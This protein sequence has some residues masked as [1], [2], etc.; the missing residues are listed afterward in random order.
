MPAAL[1]VA[2]LEVEAQHA[3]GGRRAR[4]RQARGDHPPDRAR[5]AARASGRA[6]CRPRARRGGRAGARRP[7]RRSAAAASRAARRCTRRPGRRSRVGSRPASRRIRQPDSTARRVSSAS[8]RANSASGAC[9]ARERRGRRPS[10]APVAACRAGRAGRSRRPWRGARRA[11]PRGPRRGPAAGAG[12]A[13]GRR[14]GSRARCRGRSSQSR[15]SATFSNVAGS[16]SWI[17]TAISSRSVLT[18]PPARRLAGVSSAAV[19]PWSSASAGRCCG[20]DL[21]QRAARRGRTTTPATRAH[22]SVPAPGARCRSRRSGSTP[23][24]STG[25]AP[26]AEVV[27]HVEEDDV[28]RARRSDLDRV[29][30]GDVR[31]DVQVPEVEQHPGRG[32]G[33]PPHEVAHRERVVAHPPRP[34]ED[35]REVLDRD[36]DAKRVRLLEVLRQ[37]AFLEQSALPDG[38]GVRPVIVREVQSVVGDELRAGLGGVLEQPGERAVGARR[39]RRSGRRARGARGAAPSGRAAR[40]A[41]GRARAARPA[42][43]ARPRGGAWNCTQRNPAPD[44]LGEDPARRP[45]LTRDVQPEPQRQVVRFGTVHACKLRHRAV[46]RC[47]SAVTPR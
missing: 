2:R 4:P 12:R 21:E 16:T 28:A 40:A 36:G 11:S 34:R 37:G 23:G 39:C 13:R 35:R 20:C 42:P 46:C 17:A 31:R 7:T 18:R 41:R 10:R 30:A 38:L 25:R 29:R 1:E 26:G 45:L 14:A 6:P 5:W 27:V 24:A 19:W 33:Q 8:S 44:V 15:T 22:G 32:R 43:G 9:G 3:A 47:F